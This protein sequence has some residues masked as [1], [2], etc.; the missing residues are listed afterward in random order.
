M[1]VEAGGLRRRGAQLVIVLRVALALVL[2]AALVPELSRYLAER[3]LYRASAVLRSVFAGPRE[4]LES[5]GAVAWAASTA[6]AAA[7]DLPGDWRPLNLAGSAWLLAGRADRAL[8][9]YRQALALGERPEIDVNVGRAH[10]RLGRHDRAAAAFLRAGWVSP[11]VLSWLPIAPR[12]ALRS[13]LAALE[14]KLTAGR[15]AAPP[16]L[17]D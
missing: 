16:P 9:R 4:P 3:Q 5:G 12:D 1:G 17:P 13:E 10:A 8:D 14:Q 11:A 7:A 6:A 2:V 15:L